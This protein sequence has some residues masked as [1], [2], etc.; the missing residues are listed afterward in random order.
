MLAT[1]AAGAWL[2]GDGFFGGSTDPDGAG[3]ADFAG[4]PCVGGAAP[5]MPIGFGGAAAGAGLDSGG[6]FVTAGALA[7]RAAGLASAARGAA[8]GRPAC[9]R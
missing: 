6:P 4:A 5:G 1:G 7:G 3:G 9:G 8:I 2:V